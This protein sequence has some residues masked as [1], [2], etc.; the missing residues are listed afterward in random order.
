VGI[1]AW[2][3]T[4]VLDIK[5]WSEAFDTPYSSVPES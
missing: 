1:D 3:G 4:P 5:H 2:D